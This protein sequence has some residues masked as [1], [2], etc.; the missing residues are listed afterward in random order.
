MAGLRVLGAAY[1][2]GIPLQESPGAPRWSPWSYEE[3]NS[4]VLHILRRRR[5]LLVVYV[6]NISH[7]QSVSKLKQGTEEKNIPT[8]QTTV[9]V[10]WAR[11]ASKTVVCG[12]LQLLLLHGWPW[13]LM[14]WWW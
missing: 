8:A 9:A 7:I 5:S 11:I 14:E 3:A 2:A 12:R 10:V 4:G 1:L 13:V 6:L